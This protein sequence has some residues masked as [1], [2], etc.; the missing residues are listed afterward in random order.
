MIDTKN[1]L[2]RARLCASCHVGSAE[3]DVTHD[4]LA[5][6]HP[7]LRF[8][9]A[10][11]QA[12]LERKR[13]DDSGRR[14]A[15]RV[16]LWAA[17][18]C[19]GRGGAGAME[20][21]AKRPLM[22]HGLAQMAKRRGRSWRSTTVRLPSGGTGGGK[23]TLDLLP[24]RTPGVPPWQ[25]WNVE[26]APL[27]STEFAAALERLRGEMEKSLPPAP[28]AV[29]QLA[30][31]ARAILLREIGVNNTG[32]L[33]AGGTPVGTRMALDAVARQDDFR[34]S[35][36][37]TSSPRWSQFKPRRAAP[38][39]A[40]P[41]AA[42][43]KACDLPAPIPNGPRRWPTCGPRSRGQRV[44]CRWLKSVRSWMPGDGSW[45]GANAIQS[46]I[47]S[48]IR[49]GWLLAAACWLAAV[50]LAAQAQYL[51]TRSCLQCHQTTLINKDFCQLV[52]A[53][54]WRQDDKHNRAFSLLH[55]ADTN[56]PAKVR[57]KGELV[58]RIL[59]FDLTQAF[60]DDQFQQLKRTTTPETKRR[61]RL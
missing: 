59:G 15:N 31:E 17:G 2:T 30:A 28:P 42:L 8:E 47:H 9:M 34:G 51:D 12:V 14:Q 53:S 1:L 37:A 44:Q 3:N 4:M 45:R 57:A 24:G 19:L 16:Q 7:P 22:K 10:S 56:D 50:S 26:C 36:P 43:R 38:R 13:W 55:D 46:M 18:R 61:W 6:G 58:R 25:R 39:L 60:T 48:P 54:V 40:R 5:A 49:P 11:H 21:R 23:L 52:P 29:A 20:A 35:E 41:S 32:D 27:S 33:L